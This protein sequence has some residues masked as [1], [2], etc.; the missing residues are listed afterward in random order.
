M[1]SAIDVIDESLSSVSRLRQTL[2]KGRAKQVSGHEEQSNVKATCLSWFNAHRSTLASLHEHVVFQAIDRSFQDLLEFS[3]RATS[4]SKYKSELKHLK[5][6]LVRL[7]S[8][9]AIAPSRESET[10][11]E[12]RPP[13]FAKLIAD[14]GMQSILLRRWD[15]TEKCMNAGAYLAAT[16]LMGSLLEALLL[17]RI[18]ALND[19]STVFQSKCAPTNP[20]TGKAKPLQE[21]TLNS[22]I[23]VAHDLKWIRRAGRDVGVVLRDYRNFIHPEKEFTHGVTVDESDA[24]IFWAIF[25]QLSEQ[26]VSA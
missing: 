18:N 19:K 10:E 14:K 8:H 9:V 15:E 5:S 22:Y 6:N 11:R 16:V 2:A 26:I 23:D 13:E 17:A 7:R 1:K 21:W 24:R 12:C 20:K 3:G 4:R 25:A